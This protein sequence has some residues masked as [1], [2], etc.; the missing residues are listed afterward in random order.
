MIIFMK[1]VPTHYGRTPKKNIYIMVAQSIEESII[2][3]KKI[4]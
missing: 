4:F 3:I 1:F 2:A